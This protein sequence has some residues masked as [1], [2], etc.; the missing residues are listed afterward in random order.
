[1]KGMK[2]KM[3]KRLALFML[4][5][6]MLASFMAVGSYALLGVG[7]ETGIDYYEDSS[8]AT[9]ENGNVISDGEEQGNFLIEFVLPA[10]AA[11]LVLFTGTGLFI[12]FRRKKKKARE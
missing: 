10:A 12:Y 5:L 2:A 7:D 3:I 6:I 9:D 1:M 8:S 4:A 11:L